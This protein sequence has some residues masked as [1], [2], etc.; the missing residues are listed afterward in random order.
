MAS[1]KAVR[2]GAILDWLEKGRISL[3]DAADRIRDLKLHEAPQRSTGQVLAADANGDLPVPDGSTFSEISHAYT[4]GRISRHQ[5]EVLAT[6][7]VPPGEG[8]QQA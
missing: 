1:D 2:L 8:V 7:A 6:A 4:A 5:Y 3:T